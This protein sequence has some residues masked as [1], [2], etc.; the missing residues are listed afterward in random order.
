MELVKNSQES[1]FSKADSVMKMW[2]LRSTSTTSTTFTWTWIM[3]HSEC[4]KV[5]WEEVCLL[6]I[7]DKR[8][9]HRPKELAMNSSTIFQRLEMTNK[10]TATSA[11]IKLD[12]MRKRL[13]SYHVVMPLTRPVSLNGWKSTTAAQYA[14]PSLIKIV[15]VNN[16][17]SK[18]S[19]KC[20]K[21]GTCT[22]LSISQACSEASSDCKLLCSTR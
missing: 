11:L 3:T 8:Q 19:Q 22:C 10:E 4:S 15:L 20:I 17:N 6:S 1:R 18:N 9:P 13:A 21:E 12:V 14:E 16:L 5:S 2:D 7:M